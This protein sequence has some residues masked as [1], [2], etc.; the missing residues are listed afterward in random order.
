MRG[1]VSSTCGE[2]R[3]TG[4]EKIRVWLRSVRMMINSPSSHMVFSL[5]FTVSYIRVIVA[6]F[7]VIMSRPRHYVLVVFFCSC[8]S[9]AAADYTDCGVISDAGSTGTRVY[10]PYDLANAE[11]P[12]IETIGKQK[13]GLAKVGAKAAVEDHPDEGIP[14]L[15]TLLVNAVEFMQ[16]I[17]CTPKNFLHKKYPVSILGTAGTRLLPATEREELWKNLRE[18]LTTDPILAKQPLHFRD[19]RTISGEEE[20]FFA[21]TSVNLLMGTINPAS[22]LLKDRLHGMCDLGGASTQ[23]VL[24]HR[25]LAVGDIVSGQDVFVRSFLGYG[26]K[27]FYLRSPNKHKM[28]P[29]QDFMY[30]F[31]GEGGGPP[32]WRCRGKGREGGDEESW[33]AKSQRSLIIK[34]CG[35][36]AHFSFQRATAS[37]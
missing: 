28:C 33:R 4:E 23:V 6:S 20:G 25:D 35:R 16:K 10:V 36:L 21:F 3:A 17:G 30:Y 5:P 12:R 27:E 29:S 26:T 11:G 2:K 19:L 8:F 32:P 31:L 24:P 15:R 13:G 37:W 22:R 1:Y 7:P 34:S 18:L 9:L 14:G